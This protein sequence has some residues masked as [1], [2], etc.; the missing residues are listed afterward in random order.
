MKREIIINDYNSGTRFFQHLNLNN[1]SFKGQDFSNV[2]F[3]NC[4]CKS[5]N[6]S[7]VN[8]NNTKFVQVETGL[9]NFWFSIL[10]ILI[11]LVSCFQGFLLFCFSLFT[12]YLHSAT[13]ILTTY[14]FY[15]TCLAIFF[16]TI[17]T[18]YI[19]RKFFVK[20]FNLPILF[21]LINAFWGGISGYKTFSSLI[22]LAFLGGINGLCIG[23]LIISLA[24]TFTLIKLSL[25]NIS[26]IV[27]II[28]NLLISIAI[29]NFFAINIILTL[30][31]SIYMIGLALY[32]AHDSVKTKSKSWL[33]QLTILIIAY[34]STKFYQSNLTNVNFEKTDLEYLDLRKANLINTNLDDFDKTKLLLSD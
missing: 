18:P 5:T 28:L 8:L 21:F 20:L 16:I 25:N 12:M 26:L 33:Y 30:I 17:F 22:V 6:F 1:L 19:K 4:Q 34:K 2:I 9:S 23:F 10:I 14:L 3:S 13:N 7:Q 11:L 32:L 15:L 27:A 31:F 24:I 29:A